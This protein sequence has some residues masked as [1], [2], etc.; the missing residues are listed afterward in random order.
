MRTVLR[1][2]AAP[3]DD[4]AVLQVARDHEASLLVATP[5]DDFC[6]EASRLGVGLVADVRA[7]D[8]DASR[9]LQ[10]LSQHASVL[11]VLC[12]RCLGLPAGPSLSRPLLAVTILADMEEAI[13][14]AATWAEVVVLELRPEEHP[15]AW[16][17]EYGR[18]VIAVR[19]AIDFADVGRAR[20]AC[21]RL[22]AELAPEFDLAGYFVGA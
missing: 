8:G 5:S 9:E 3:A 4:T 10:R 12:D 22:Q 18:P 2:A 13:A 17:A 7:A 19:R 21:D 6:R 1:G 11:I 20:N 16:V 14:D 15:P